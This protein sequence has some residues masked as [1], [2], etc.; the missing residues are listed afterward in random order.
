[1]HDASGTTR[2]DITLLYAFDGGGAHVRYEKAAVGQAYTCVGCGKPVT[3][4]KGHE[5]VNG[6]WRP[7]FAHTTESEDG[8]GESADHKS[9]VLLIVERVQPSVGSREPKGPWVISR[10]SCCK[11]EERPYELEAHFDRAKPEVRADAEIA[12]PALRSGAADRIPDVTV[13]SSSCDAQ[14]YVEVFHTH[15]VD[16]EKAKDYA[17]KRWIEVVAREILERPN[18]WRFD[19]PDCAE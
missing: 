8:C 17:G 18:Y 15:R 4:R 3:F 19:G 6:T 11:R 7:H 16:E 9:A 1:M 2:R 10:C 13:S 5:R 12:D 14:L